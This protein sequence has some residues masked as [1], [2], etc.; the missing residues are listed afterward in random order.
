MSTEGVKRP[1]STVLMVLRDTPA[2]ALSGGRDLGAKVEFAKGYAKMMYDRDL[3]DRLV[4]EVLDASPYAE[5]FTLMNVL[6]Q[7]EAVQLRAEEDDYF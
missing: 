2:I 3:Y 5:G 4:S 1:T 7:K 6:A